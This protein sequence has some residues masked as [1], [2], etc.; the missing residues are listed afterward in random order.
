MKRSELL[1]TAVQIPVDY[2][3]IL[4]A[5]TVAYH[6]RFLEIFTS[7]QEVVFHTTLFEF[8]QL[9]TLVI[10]LALLTFAMVGFYQ[11]RRHQSVADDL[12]K[13][14]LGL[15]AAVTAVI[16]YIFFTRELYESR[17][18]LLAT[19][20]LAILI[21]TSGRFLLRRL[22]VFLF[23]YNV[24]VHRVV[25]VGNG[26]T[27]VRLQES[28]EK[29]HS[30]HQVVGAYARCEDGMFRKLRQLAKNPGIDEVVVTN[31]GLEREDLFRLHQLAEEYK[32]E[33][34]IVPDL[35]GTLTPNFEVH[36][37]AGIPLFE[38]RH[39][40]LEGW[41][42]ILKR[43]IDILGSA[44]GLLM[45]S[46]LFFLV[47]LIVKMDSKGPVFVRLPRVNRDGTFGL[48][49]FRSMVDNAHAL[50]KELLANNERKGPLFK[51]ANDPRITRVGR[52]L[53]SSRLDEL[54]QLWNV[55]KGEMSLV[56]PRPHEPEEVAQYAAHHKRV[57]GINSGMTGLAQVSGSS[58][59]DFEEEVRLDTS[60]MEN[61]S[62]RLDL[63]ILFRT[64]R[65]VLGRKFGS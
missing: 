12:G 35:F 58:D 8:L 64:L 41:W 3:M 56:G 30:G 23:R 47:A 1:F 50:K 24:G 44:F 18:L 36:D 10:P 32:W 53:R 48:Y 33:F 55:L 11:I 40:P 21:V 43:L 39:T 2:A 25:I 20:V 22:R 60:Y 63:A 31:P 54:P 17:F 34:S 28:Y 45:L 61:W 4:L 49:K 14:M 42:R 9:V 51:M 52:V 38:M 19:W 46:P 26:K 7:I 13:A 16:F 6:L 5:A 27:Q 59:L 15:S 57:L 29:P 62:L 65:V 37:V